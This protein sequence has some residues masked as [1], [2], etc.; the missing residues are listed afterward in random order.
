MGPPPP[1][2]R[3]GDRLLG[4]AR[5]RAV[6]S[7]LETEGIDFHTFVA[8]LETW[9]FNDLGD[10]RTRYRYLVRATDRSP[11]GMAAFEPI[12]A[13]FREMITQP[14]WGDQ[15]RRPIAEGAAMYGLDAP[16][17]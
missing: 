16:A 4:S 7:P 11:D 13:F 14:T 12:A 1:D 6:L 2:L 9:E 3:A 8:A 17:N 15:T 5:R 10:G